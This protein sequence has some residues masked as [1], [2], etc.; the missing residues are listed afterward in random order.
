[1][2]LIAISLERKEDPVQA[3]K[4]SQE[5]FLPDQQPLPLEL[6]RLLKETRAKFEGGDLESTSRTLIQALEVARAKS[7]L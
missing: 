7:Y 5:L 4:Y 6:E 2:A 1:M 3:F